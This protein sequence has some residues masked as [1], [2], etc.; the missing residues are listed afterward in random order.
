MTS[1]TYAQIPIPKYYQVYL[2]LKEKIEEGVYPEGT[3]IPS[4]RHLVEMHEVSRITIVKAVDLLVQEGLIETRQGTGNFVKPVR[5][6]I[7]PARLKTV[8]LVIPG[9]L[10]G[11]ISS[12]LTGIVEQAAG[13]STQVQ[14][15]GPQ[16][17][18]KNSIF[19]DELCC[20]DLDGVIVYP[21]ASGW[22]GWVKSIVESG[23]P[24]VLIDR[25]F[26]ELAC[27]HV[28]FD[29]E[30]AAYQLTTGMI[31]HGMRRI[32]FI[33]QVEINTTSVIDRLKGFQRAHLEFGIPL[34]ED[35]MWF[36][37]YSHLRGGV[38]LLQDDSTQNL[39]EHIR[40]YQP[41]GIFAIN[42]RVGEK[43]Y[44]DLMTLHNRQLLSLINPLNQATEPKASYQVGQAG[45]YDHDL[46]F[47]NPYYH[48]VAMQDGRQLGK[49][50][51][52]LVL[53]RINRDLP[54]P[55]PVHQVVSMQV[56]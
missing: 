4:E 43:F 51:F 29:D 40:R 6:A 23:V 30:E 9:T 26:P 13:A 37:A 22:Q 34:D 52:D 18:R 38:D 55:S 41:D 36:E 15:M 17:G 24:V 53:A 28:V 19:F 1:N 42:H 56:L 25:Y 47:Q 45:I 2:A 20:G 7:A 39:D 35:M 8:A 32:A 44:F 11:Y 12:V 21:A 46:F 27:D 16:I 54:D 5:K 50:A 3:A 49:A 10:E 33:P 31:R 14:L 48:G